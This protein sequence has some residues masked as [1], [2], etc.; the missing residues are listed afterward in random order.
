[1][2]A[3]TGSWWSKEDLYKYKWFDVD[4]MRIDGGLDI[5]KSP[6]RDLLGKESLV[7]TRVV[8]DLNHKQEH[9]IRFVNFASTAT[10]HNITRPVGYKFILDCLDSHLLNLVRSTKAFSSFGGI[11]LGQSNSS[12]SSGQQDGHCGVHGAWC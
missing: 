7:S 12:K 2:R 5:E 10:H 9:M 1:V 3:L 6:L 8:L 11:V 4:L